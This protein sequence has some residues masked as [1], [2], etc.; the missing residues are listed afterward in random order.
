MKLEHRIGQLLIVGIPSTAIDN[1]TREMLEMIQPGG[2]LLASRN[3]ESA[4]Q[5]VELTSSLRSILNVSPI[6]AVDQ[7]G[8]SVDR[9]RSIFGPMPSASL[10]RK[11]ADASIASRMGEIT[12]DALRMMGFNTNFAPVLDVSR[13]DSAENGLRNRCLGDTSALVIR[14]TGA[15][16]EGLQRN[17]LI[18]VGKHFPGLGAAMVDSHVQLPT[19]E[20]SRDELKA[21][22]LLP[23][24]ELFS[25][26][27]AR[28]NAVIVGHAHYVAFDG[29]EPLPSSLSKN[30]TTSLLREE[31]GF[32]GLVIT[33][34]IEMG[35]VTSSHS[36]ADA[37][38][39]AI[40]AGA[41]L[42]LVAGNIEHATSAWNSMVE[43][44]RQ[45]RIS[46]QRI[47][48]S[49]D[50]IARIKSMI[51]PPSQFSDSNLAQLQGLVKELNL[52]LQHSK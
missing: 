23:Y 52:M 36:V 39:E 41:D 15:Y 46:L 1:E 40:E 8:G 21:V 27:S 14:L 5:L 50:Y 12:A 9:L 42:V 19:I 44:A 45:E 11:A 51:S 6:V 4:P 49:F 7:E 30:V 22:D 16:L 20:L 47:G 18:G 17:G 35:A 38:V 26:I 29:H 31:L 25:K 33:D 43:A 3:I 10:L 2:V 28:L 48:Q 32:K 37:A 34:D 24:I 13:D